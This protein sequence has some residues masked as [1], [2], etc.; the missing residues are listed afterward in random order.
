MIRLLIILCG[1]RTNMC[2][3]RRARPNR[4]IVST[5]AEE[6]L[7][8]RDKLSLSKTKLKKLIL[9]AFSYDERSFLL[10]TSL[11]FDKS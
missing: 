1:R 11:F 5:E 7:T 2:E 9:L 10:L 4:A 8:Y 3:D 6:A